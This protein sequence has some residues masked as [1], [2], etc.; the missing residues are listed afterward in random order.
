MAKIGYYQ[1]KS[2]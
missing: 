2:E 1:Y